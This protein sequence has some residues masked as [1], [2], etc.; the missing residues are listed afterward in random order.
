M[1]GREGD[2]E[3]AAV[4]APIVQLA[5]PSAARRGELNLFLQTRRIAG[6]ADQGNARADDLR[7]GVARPLEECVIHEGE[8]PG[9]V[10]DRDHLRRALHRLGQEA[11]LLV[12]FA[13]FGHVGEPHDHVAD[14]PV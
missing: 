11:Q 10:G 8:S 12:R 13:L 2:E 5:V 1:C 7:F 14:G 9:A 4:L 3:F 6:R